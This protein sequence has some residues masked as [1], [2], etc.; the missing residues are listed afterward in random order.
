MAGLSVFWKLSGEKELYAY[1]KQDGLDIVWLPT[2]IRMNEQLDVVDN[3]GS[4][5]VLACVTE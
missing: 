2:F 4:M 5:K 3:G 1:I